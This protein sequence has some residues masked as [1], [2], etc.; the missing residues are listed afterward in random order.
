[1]KSPFNRAVGAVALLA[2]V[3]PVVAKDKRRLEAEVLN[4][5]E[6]DTMLS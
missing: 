2:V 3:F 6:I 5:G 1:V 4:D